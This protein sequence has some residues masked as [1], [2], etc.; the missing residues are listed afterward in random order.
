LRRFSSVKN[1]VGF[2]L[3]AL[4]E[5]LVCA[6]F[7]LYPCDLKSARNIQ[8]AMKESG[9]MIFSVARIYA[10]SGEALME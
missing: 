6:A 9:D 5:A 8:G 1:F 7:Y 3:P 10:E 2:T 4:N